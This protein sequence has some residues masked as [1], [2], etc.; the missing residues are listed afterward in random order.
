MDA[1]F[2]SGI[3]DRLSLCSTPAQIEATTLVPMVR[4][5]WVETWFGH[6]EDDI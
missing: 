4:W 3:F 5:N 1:G 2:L 6:N